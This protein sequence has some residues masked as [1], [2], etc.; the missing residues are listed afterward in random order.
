MSTSTHSSLGEIV[1]L[2]ATDKG[3]IKL[4]LAVNIPFKTM[5]ITFNVFDKLLLR[6]FEKDF[7]IGDFVQVDYHYKGT[8]TQLDQLTRMMRFDNCPICYTN[9][10]PIDAQRF[11]CPGCA[12]MSDDNHK[13]RISEKM[14]LLECTPTQYKYS[15]GYKI[16]F[17]SEDQEYHLGA[18][19]FKNS[20]LFDRLGNLRINHF[21]HVHGWKNK[22]GFKSTPPEIVNIHDIY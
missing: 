10:E 14:K 12:L 16:K 1:K 17:I 7:D 4:V 22:Q 18:V 11:D 19:V 6:D 2:Q 5:S 8:F 15:S 13:E 9:L 3:Y 20:P 21:Y